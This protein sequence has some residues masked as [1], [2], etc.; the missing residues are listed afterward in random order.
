[1][2][3]TI[4]TDRI[5]SDASYASSITVASPMV[6]S[7]TINMT[8]GSITGNVNID[9]GTLFVDSVGNKVGI[10]TT[11]PNVAKLHITG[12]LNSEYGI[13]LQSTR[14][15]G[16]TY[17]FASS[18]TN[19]DRLSIYDITAGELERFAVDSSGRVT[20]P[21]QP[22]FRAYRSTTHTTQSTDVPFDEILLNAG[23]HYNPANGRFTAPVSGVYVFIET[24]RPV[25]G[26]SATEIEFR[27]NGSRQSIHNIQT[28]GNMHQTSTMIIK[29]DVND[30]VTV[31]A[32]LN[33]QFDDGLWNSF[34]GYLLG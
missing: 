24:H 33:A 34:S 7:N 26:G 4:I 13:R 19:A 11:T 28:A 21:Y 17:G 22:A 30:Y 15:T 27:K 9:N 10:G 23:S 12:D 6:V 1:M 5:E 16:R 18:G 2:A 29:L 25:S 20:M 32:A 3:G 31:Y 14:G 8:G